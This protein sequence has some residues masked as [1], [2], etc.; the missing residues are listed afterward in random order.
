M[1][2]A[3]CYTQCH[4]QYWGKRGR[5]P[6]LTEKKKNGTKIREKWKNPGQKFGKRGG[7]WE[8]KVKMGGQSCP[9]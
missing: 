1:L 5:E 8:E 7:N 6:P 4:S 9:C 2:S 3:T